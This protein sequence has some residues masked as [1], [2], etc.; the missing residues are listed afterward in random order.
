MANNR[1][2]NILRSKYEDTKVSVHPETEVNSLKIVSDKEVLERFRL[3]YENLEP[4]R[5][6][7]RRCIN[8]TFGRQWSDL[9]DDPD[10]N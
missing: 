7:V 9:I 4:M 1:T 2:L 10:S 8:Y 6:R 3:A 5:R